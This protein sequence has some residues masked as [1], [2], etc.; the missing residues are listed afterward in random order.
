MA[1]FESLVRK[2]RRSALACAASILGEVGDAEDVVQDAMIQAC[3]RLGALR[4]PGQF[5]GWLMVAVRRRALNALRSPHRRRRAAIEE[6]GD[7]PAGTTPHEEYLAAR[8]RQLVWA[9][10]A[11]L[12]ERERDVLILSDLD[13]LPHA[14]VAAIL[15]I[16]VFMSRR[17]LVKARRRARALLQHANLDH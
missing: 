8:R 16:S 2:Y 10:L 1:A 15:G 17:Y 14:E 7:A 4:S 9:A 5:G 12:P 3:E 11:E 6:A 13:G